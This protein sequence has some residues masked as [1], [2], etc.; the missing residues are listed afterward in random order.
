M[1]TEVVD[2]VCLV[3]AS[4]EGIPVVVERVSVEIIV[5]PATPE[6]IQTTKG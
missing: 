1:T 4:S 6:V 5:G 3:A 2:S